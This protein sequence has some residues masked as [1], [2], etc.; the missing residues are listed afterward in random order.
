MTV[1]QDEMRELLREIHGATK[2]LRHAIKE[3]RQLSDDLHKRFTDTALDLLNGHEQRVV[4]LSDGMYNR[5]D[6][7]YRRYFDGLTAAIQKDEMKVTH[8][9]LTRSFADDDSTA[10]AFT[11]NIKI[12]PPDPPAQ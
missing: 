4:E 12:L 3:A 9:A 2:D 8:I 7:T 1:E 6:S 5:L 11:E 10:D